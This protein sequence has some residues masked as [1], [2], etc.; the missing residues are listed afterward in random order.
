MYEGRTMRKMKQLDVRVP[1]DLLARL[2][3]IAQTK[4]LSRSETIREALRE[5]VER[6]QPNL[7]GSAPLKC[8]MAR[9]GEWK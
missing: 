9:E 3:E 2:S 6:A 8:D 4:G 7:T 5:F 1:E